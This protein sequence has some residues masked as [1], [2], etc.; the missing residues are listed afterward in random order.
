MALRYK[1][2]HV[3]V[4]FINITERKQAENALTKSEEKLDQLKS[5]APVIKE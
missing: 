2:D 5:V 1:T 3:V 4:I